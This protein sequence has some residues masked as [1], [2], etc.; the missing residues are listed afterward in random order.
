MVELCVTVITGYNNNDYYVAIKLQQSTKVTQFSLVSSR[1]NN[2]ATMCFL[3]RSTGT[4]SGQ[5]ARCLPI[6]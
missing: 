5:C 1:N 6:L 4:S 3:L 2:S